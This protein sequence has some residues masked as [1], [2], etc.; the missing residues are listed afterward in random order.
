MAQASS[1]LFGIT[2]LLQFKARSDAA[3]AAKFE[4][5]V[6]AKGEELG[7]IQREADRKG[8]LAEAIAS[9]T[10]SAG[11]RGIAAFEGSPLSVLEADIE[12]EQVATERDIFQTRLSA[13]T[14]RTRGRLAEKTAKAGAAFSL[15]GDVG[16]SLQLAK[17]SPGSTPRFK[18]TLSQAGGTGQATVGL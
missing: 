6:A 5:E 13:L 1:S 16:K 11:A 9:Q 10:A 4:G 14:K 15:L 3:S 7:A 2:S 12:K 17:A 18:G 8:R